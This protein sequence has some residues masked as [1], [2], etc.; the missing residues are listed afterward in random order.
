[1][2]GF[3]SYLFFLRKDSPFCVGGK[4]KQKK[5]NSIALSLF[6]LSSFC[7]YTSSTISSHFP[8][9]IPSL[10]LS[11]FFSFF[12]SGSHFLYITVPFFFISFQL[13]VISYSLSF[14]LH[15]PHIFLAMVGMWAH[16]H[17]QPGLYNW[18]PPSSAQ[19]CTYNI[20]A[21]QFLI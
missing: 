13:S 15:L 20:V 5:N 14:S 11:V 3:F 10:S 21:F 2:V 18:L 9:T 4:R 7:C 17:D 16:S 19:H 8:S 1:M 12:L 6:C